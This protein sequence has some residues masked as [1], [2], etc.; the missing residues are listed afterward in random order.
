MKSSRRRS[1]APVGDKSFSRRISLRIGASVLTAQRGASRAQV[2][3]A[4]KLTRILVPVDFS[5]ASAKPLCYASAIAK[6]H[7]AKIILLHITK[8]I[9][10]SADYGYGPVNRQV[11]D[12]AQMRKDRS[13]LRRSAGNHLSPGAI[14]NI[15]IRS[16]NAPEQII[17][18]AKKTRAD[19]I[20]LY[21]HEA[22]DSNS[23][24][25]HKTAEQVMRSAQ[26]PVLVVRSHEHDFVQLVRTRRQV[27]PRI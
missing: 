10:F 9:S 17:W 23:V 24:G 13:R 12:D 27:R 4:I 21:S 15:I 6:V 18:A 8:P 16:G 20:V 5:R 1:A 22:N 2:I 26:C 19:L 3:P 14:E 11:S 25:S 7:G